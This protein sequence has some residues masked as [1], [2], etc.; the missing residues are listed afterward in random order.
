MVFGQRVELSRSVMAWD[1]GVGSARVPNAVLQHGVS[2][3]ESDVG[4]G[5]ILTSGDVDS[6]EAFLACDG[7]G[8]EQLPINY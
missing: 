1:G 8:L 5:I 2:R 4:E 6:S 3:I 7:S